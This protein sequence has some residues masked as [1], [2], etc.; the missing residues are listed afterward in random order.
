MQI[1][2]QMRSTVEQL[3]WVE[4]FYPSNMAKGMA[5][6]LESFSDWLKTAKKT[7]QNVESDKIENKTPSDKRFACISVNPLECH[8]SPF[9]QDEANFN[10]SKDRLLTSEISELQ[11]KL[12]ALLSENHELRQELAKASGVDPSRI[13]SGRKVCTACWYRIS[14]CRSSGRAMCR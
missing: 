8:C 4:R 10:T 11:A 7:S 2:G 6:S 12:Q 5:G 14:C 1:Y 9:S 13:R 3:S